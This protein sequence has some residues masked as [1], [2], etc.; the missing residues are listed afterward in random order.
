MRR[1]TLARERHGST[2][3]SATSRRWPASFWSTRTFSCSRGLLRSRG[4]SPGYFGSMPLFARPR[5]ALLRR[6]DRLLHRRVGGQRI[7]V[8]FARAAAAAAA[9]AAAPGAG[10]GAAL[11]DAALVG[12]AAA[13]PAL[14]DHD[15]A[16]AFAL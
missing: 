8:R 1:W 10:L 3:A 9:R 6:D 5:G 11:L 13:A 4:G 15:V 2:N 14:G 7:E 16:Q 12:G